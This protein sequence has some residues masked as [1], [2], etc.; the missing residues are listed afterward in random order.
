MS[1]FEE[2][3]RYQANAPIAWVPNEMI[4]MWADWVHGDPRTQELPDVYS[5]AEVR[6][7]RDFHTTWDRLAERL[8]RDLPALPQ[9]QQL[10]EWDELRRAGDAAFKVFEVRGTM[11]DDVET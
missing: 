7:I 4:E 2:Q 11:P 5:D 6:A 3:Q 10:P 9:V 8:P 1:S